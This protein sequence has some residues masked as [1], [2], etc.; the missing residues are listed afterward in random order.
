VLLETNSRTGVRDGR[1]HRFTLPAP[2]SYPFQWFWDSCFHAIVWSRFDRA[3]AADE[4]RSL[5]AWQRENGFVPHVVFWDG[6]AIRTRAVWHHLE[7]RSFPFA[8]PPRTTEYVQPPVLAQA[9]ERVGGEFAREALP[10]AAAF[11]RY[12]A[13]ERDYDGD[14]LISIVAQFESGLDYSPLY[15][16]AAG[17]RHLN[18]FS[19]YLRSRWTELVNKALGFDLRR[20]FRLTDHHQEDVLVNALYGDGLRAL[21]RV[22]RSIADDGLAAW[23][24]AAAALSAC[25]TLFPMEVCRRVWFGAAECAGLPDWLRAR[26]RGWLR[27]TQVYTRPAGPPVL[28]ISLRLSRTRPSPLER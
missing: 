22:A 18:P 19:I 4:L 14:G 21:A 8:P 9:I 25:R 27:S 3:R 16:D 17:V 11:Y 26:V 28:R 7:S 12:L 10:A 13:R 6:S 20:I 2:A 15:G 23:A 1:T 24:A 5:L